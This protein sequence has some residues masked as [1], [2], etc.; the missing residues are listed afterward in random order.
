MPREPRNLR[1]AR[2]GGRAW[3]HLA[4]ARR[5]IR[6]IKASPRAYLGLAGAAL[7]ALLLAL[8]GCVGAPP[9]DVENACRIF[10]EKPDWWEAARAA[11]KR[12]GTPASVQLAIIRQE[13][14]FQYDAE[15]PRDTVL[16]IPMWWRISSAYGYAQVKDET[17][18]W[19]RE[20]TGNGWA[21]RD[22][23]EDVSDFI[24]WYTDVSQR[25]LGVPKTDAY[26]Q[27]LA[28][29]EG[30]GGWTRKTYRDKPWLVRVARKVE[31]YAGTYRTQL[32]ACRERLDEKSTG[33][34]PF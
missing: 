3:R 20:K 34:W 9:K 27:Y 15:P 25:T 22:D 26:N 1:S 2:R 28:Y 12:W 13:S 17:W 32:A 24:G 16:G 23:F 19:Y 11:E 30:Q 31:R 14:S 10:E 5:R 7:A 33:W 18:D 6:R 21:D 4:G 8:P 29:H